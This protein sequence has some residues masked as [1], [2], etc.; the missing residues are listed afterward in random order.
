MI[1]LKLILFLF[2]P[3]MLNTMNNITAN[4][5]KL[6]PSHINELTQKLKQHH[7]IYRFPVKAELFED[8]FDNVINGITT[9][10][11]GGGHSV[12]ADVVC[13]TTH[14]T[15]QLKSGDL[16]KNKNTIKW[17]GH[18]T[19]KFKTIQEK[20]DF[21][22]SHKVDQYIMLAR[23]KKDWDKGIK[24]YYLLCFESTKIDYSKLLWQEKMGRKG[25]MTGWKGMST[26]N[27]STPYN[28]EINKSMSDQ[29]WTTSSLSYLCEPIEIN[30]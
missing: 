23:D 26:D 16:D 11:I 30:I 2:L 1:Y 27:N 7:T 14:T 17:N 22:S 19:T 15:F 21:I 13:N 20:I 28:A 10:W 5:F 4:T 8:L 25:E 6:S 12:S 3:F 29:L 9:T 24:K 18:R